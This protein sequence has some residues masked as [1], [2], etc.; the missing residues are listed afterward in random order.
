M[1]GLLPGVIWV[2]GASLL[3]SSGPSIAQSVVL[4]SGSFGGV[5]ARAIGPA[6]MS[7]RIAAL[8]AVAADPI[9]IYIG[10]ASGGV[11]KSDDGGVTFRP[12]F[13]D[14]KQSIGAVRIDP[15][16]P[17]R[18]W[19]GTGESWVRNSVSVGD[20]IYRTDD[21]GSTWKH[22]GLRDS[23]RIAAIEVSN[24]DSNHVF[25]CVTGALWSDSSERGVYR[26]RDGGETWERVLYVD[27]GTGCSDLVIDAANPNI[28][29]AGMWQFRR[30]PDWFTSGGKG[31][32]L[33]RS[34]DGG[35]TWQKVESGLPTTDK[36]RISLAMAPSKP[37]RVYAIVESSDTALF[38]S[39]DLGSQ[40]EQISNGFGV[41]VRPFYFGTL[42]VDPSDANR[43]FRPSLFFSRSDDGGKSFGGGLNFSVTVHVDHHALWIDP[44][45]PQH[46][47]LGTDGGAYVSY[48][49]GNRW[50]MV[51]SLPI[52]QFYHVSV[53]DQWPYQVYGGLQDNGSWTGPSRHPGGV[54]N[55]H[56][57]SIGFGDGFWMFAD[58]QDPNIVYSQ[59]QGGQF[60]RFDRKIGEGQR[61]RP[62][63]EDGQTALRFNWNAPLHLSPTGDGTIYVGSQ[64]L[65]RSRDR[66]ETW[67]TLSP[68]LTTND[69]K[70]QRQAIS[71]GLTID[72]STAENN[73]TIYTI[74]E[75]PRNAELIW[76][77]TDDG[78]VQLTRDGGKSWSNVT[79]AIPGLA[80]GN[81]ISRIEASPHDEAVAFLTADDHRRGDMGVYVYRTGDF[82][83]TWQRLPTAGVEGY[84]WVIKQDPVNPRL[85]Y[86]GTEF[87]LYISLDEGQSWAR[88]K[89][90]LPQVAVHDLVI[91]PREHDLVIATHGRGIYIIDDLTPLR[92]LT[93]EVLEQEVSLLPARPAVMISGGAMQDFPGDDGFVGENPPDAAVITYYLKKRHLF[94]DLKVNVYDQQ[95]RLIRSI[96]G[97]QRRGINRVYW[98]MRMKPPKL[99]P[100]TSLAPA[101]TGPRVLEGEYRVELIKGKERIEGSIQL[102]ADPRSPHSAEDRALQQTMA[103]ELYARLEDLTYLV[104]SLNRVRDQ[105]R[106]A[107]A[108]LAGGDQRRLQATADALDALVG[109]IVSTK[110]GFVSGDEKLREDLGAL[111]GAVVGYDGRPTGGQQIERDR[112]LGLL[113]RAER[114]ADELLQ[115]ELSAS[116]R[117]LERRGLEPLQRQPRDQ[118]QSESDAAQGGAGVISHHH[119][120]SIHL[121]P[122]RLLRSRF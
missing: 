29:F 102:V 50:R 22:L 105:A 87:G 54:R 84:A 103:L 42:E 16:N 96:P 63:L 71:G 82:G 121:L 47:I 66:G 122:D 100:A 118:W 116:N 69:P 39:D 94:G 78:L 74:A 98:P 45:N 72:N 111:Y 41:Q 24:Q 53:D 108:N 104:E 119:R 52:S 7:G 35:S 19:V 8:D 97:E 48:D 58:P 109:S 86:L 43:V 68:D 6:V 106:N 13:D 15:Q 20:G 67:Q 89:E 10:A 113:K 101:F 31:S 33:Y 93:P 44:R 114:D 57:D 73:T 75:S 5:R 12:V 76:V 4:D 14:Y 80:R 1:R 65:H 40:W 85:L 46:L 26:T 51:G 55:K 62:G 59:Y 60:F 28:L 77:G 27:Q 23:E 3:A 34:V 112:L 90:N 117:I 95:G 64:Y 99:P 92:A 56:W 107:A 17:Q 32:G 70:R 61:I 110:A 9:T 79:A 38:R 18:V 81:W 21:G 2:L 91:H 37:G 25:A 115:R 30:Y 83:K 120:R 49:R 11:W 88:F 36:G